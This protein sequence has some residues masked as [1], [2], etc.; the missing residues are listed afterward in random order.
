M[1]G[2]VKNMKSADFPKGNCKII[3]DRLV[4]KYAPHTALSLLKLQSEFHNSTLDSME[5][6]PDEWIL[7]LEGLQIQM[8]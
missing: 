6:D 8:N 3:W 5:K 4:S 7:H 2:L 1:L